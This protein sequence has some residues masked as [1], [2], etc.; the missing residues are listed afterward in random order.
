[1]LDGLFLRG[2]NFKQHPLQGG[3]SNLNHSSLLI[4][5]TNR[6]TALSVAR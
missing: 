5:M 3:V 4:L 2:T 6:T 1:M